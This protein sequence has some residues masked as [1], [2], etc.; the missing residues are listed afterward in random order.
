MSSARSYTETFDVT[1]YKKQASP[2]LYSEISPEKK[3]FESRAMVTEVYEESE[4]VV[5]SFA[6]TTA[7]EE[8]L[9]E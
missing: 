9:E 8:V 4:N 5:S 2:V 7:T 6:P 1:V 3:S